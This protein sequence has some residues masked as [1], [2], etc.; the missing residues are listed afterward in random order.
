MTFF[1][2]KINADLKRKQGRYNY[3]DG[4]PWIKCNYSSFHYPNGKC[5]AYGK[6][7]T[8]CNRYKH[9]ER[10]CPKNINAV[11]TGKEARC[12]KR[13]RELLGKPGFFL[14]EREPEETFL[15]E[16]IGKTWRED[17]ESTEALKVLNMNETMVRIILDTERVY[18]LLNVKPTIQSWDVTLKGYGGHKVPSIGKCNDYWIKLV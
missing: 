12:S 9:F 6:R 1:E 4:T 16:C 15:V 14:R 7:C 8:G 17:A 10:R 3:S 13:T 2:D 18:D 11:K 5:Q